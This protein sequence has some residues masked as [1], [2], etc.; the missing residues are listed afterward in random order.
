[1]LAKRKIHVPLFDLVTSLSDVTDMVNPALNDHHKKVAYIAYSL[2]HEMGLPQD[3][4][5][6]LL[7]AGMLHDIGALS[8]QDKMKALNFE[9]ASPHRHAETGGLLLKSFAPLADIG[10]LVAHHHV[11]WENGAGKTH[12]GRAVPTASHLLHLADRVA[13]L[14]KKSHN[15]SGMARK[16]TRTIEAASGEMFVPEAVKAFCSLADKKFFWLDVTSSSLNRLLSRKIRLQTIE[17]D[18]VGISSLAQ[19]FSRVIDFRSRFTA[20]HSSGVATI[21]EALAQMVGYS[22]NE[23]MMMKVAGYL[24][25]LG[26]LAVATEILEKPAPLTRQEK[27]I[28]H[29]HPFYTYRALEHIDDFSTIIRWGAFHHECPNGKGYPFHIG[30]NDLPLGSRIIAAADVF[31]AITEDRPYRPGMDEDQSLRVIGEMARDSLLDA[32]ISALLIHNYREMSALRKSVQ[33]DLSC[34]YADLQSHL[35][36]VPANRNAEGRL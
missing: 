21:A 23:C 5:R 15:L 7:L 28:V 20:T 30:K 1:V 10:E 26:K 3:E 32:K 8:L 19:V 14:L 6:D 18:L 31:T 34:V 17:L 35:D 27:S 22:E 29:S 12:D 9:V 24:H 4:C 36:R 25:D 11:R 16:I 2:G 33:A 13:V